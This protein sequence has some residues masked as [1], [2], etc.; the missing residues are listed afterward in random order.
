VRANAAKGAG[1]VRVAAVINPAAGGVTE[2]EADAR[3]RRIHDVLDT[4]IPAAWRSVVPGSQMGA[5]AEDMVRRGARVIFAGGGDGSVSTIAGVAVRTDVALGILPLGTRNHFARDLGIPMNVEHWA[6]LVHALPERRV[7]V[8]EVNGRVFVNNVSVGIYPLIVRERDRLVQR[9]GLSKS[10]G[11]LLAA[12]RILVR[13]PRSRYVLQFPDRTKRR[14]TPI[15]FVGNNEYRT[16]LFPEARRHTFEEG[17]LWVCIARATHPLALLRLA[18]RA[19]LADADDVDELDAALTE[20]L[21]IDARRRR[22]T[23]AI[24]GEPARLATP[25]HLR[26]LPQALRVIAT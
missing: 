19:S 13:F 21:R 23:A 16:G 25:V 1:S 14:F 9:S 24:D 3:L 20:T 22:I 2:A 5:A 11:Q 10:V 15:L 17:R 12:V 7:D 8:G 26:S 6:D 4:A 18:W